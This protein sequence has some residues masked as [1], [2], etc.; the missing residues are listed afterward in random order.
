MESFFFNIKSNG[1]KNV[2]N[3]L[4][5]TCSF[6]DNAELIALIFAPSHRNLFNKG[7]E[8]LYLVDLAEES[9]S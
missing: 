7:Q 8:R 9:F 3:V 2:A 1:K 4:F 6:L 5:D